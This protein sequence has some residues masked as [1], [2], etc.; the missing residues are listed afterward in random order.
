MR[1]SVVRYGPYGYARNEY[2][3]PLPSAFPLSAS[4]GVHGYGR[5]Q[6]QEDS[7]RIHRRIRVEGAIHLLAAQ[8]PQ[9]Q[10]PRHVPRG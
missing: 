4:R 10:E 1:G 9:P 2:T 6:V 5:R 8:N 7:T 3:P